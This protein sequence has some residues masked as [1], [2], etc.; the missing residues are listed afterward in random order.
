[1][2][3]KDEK[4]TEYRTMAKKATEETHPSAKNKQDSKKPL[5][6]AKISSC[7]ELLLDAATVRDDFNKIMTEIVATVNKSSTSQ[8]GTK[9]SHG[10]SGISEEKD[11]T[12]TAAPTKL[13]VFVSL[14]LTTKLP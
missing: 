10:T 13:F 1:M 7:V 12:F 8:R 3:Y 4:D 14:E 2:M 9:H 5:H 11:A 6:P